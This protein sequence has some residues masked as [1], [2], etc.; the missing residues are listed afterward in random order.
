MSA[1][2][3]IDE[4]KTIMHLTLPKRYGDRQSDRLDAFY[5]EQSSSYDLFRDRLLHGREQLMRAIPVPTGGSLVDMGGGTGRNLEWLGERLVSVASVTVVDLCASLLHIADQRIRSNGWQNVRTRLADV[6]TYAPAEG[7]VDAVTFS[8]SLTMIPN[9]FDAVENA[10]AI[11][12]PGGY[13]GVVDFYV[14]DKWPN[15]GMVRHSGFY[16]NFWPAWFGYS[17]VFLNPDHL[18]Y[19]SRLFEM[20]RLDEKKGKVPYLPGLKAPF[21]LFVGRKPFSV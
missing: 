12:K 4:F 14:S 2:A 3:F 19:L 16:R 1:R 9:W 18:T 15:D 5:A 11:L 13:I 10:Y 6:T 17:N 20:I 7:L 8:Y 21:Y